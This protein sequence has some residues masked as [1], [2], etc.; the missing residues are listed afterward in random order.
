MLTNYDNLL[1]IQHPAEKHFLSAIII[2]PLDTFGSGFRLCSH[3]Q[4]QAELTSVSRSRRRVVLVV[5]GG[6]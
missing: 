6:G 3:K 4:H 5:V 2:M 1:L